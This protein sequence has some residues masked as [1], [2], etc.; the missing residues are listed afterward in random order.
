[1]FLMSSSS[2]ATAFCASLPIQTS[3][4]PQ[5]LSHHHFHHHR[6]LPTLPRSRPRIHPCHNPT[7]SSPHLITAVKAPVST[8]DAVKHALRLRFPEADIS[9]VLDSFSSAMSGVTLEKDTD[10]ARHQRA[11]SFMANISEATPFHDIST[12]DSYNW[13]RNLEANAQKIIDEFNSVTSQ[14]D[15]AEKG[16]NVWAS[17]VV[18]AATTYGPDWRTLVLQDRVWDDTN[19][20]L[21]PVTTSLLKECGVPS[22]EAFFARQKAGTG[23][24][25]HTD[26]C[27]F[28]LTMHLGLVVPEDGKSWIQVGGEKQTWQKGKAMVFD[29][30][31]FHETMNEDDN[32]D[33]V[34][35]IIRFWHPDM[36]E[37]ERDAMA[38]LFQLIEDPDEHPAVAEASELLE[39]ANMQD[40]GGSPSKRQGAVGKK[41]AKKNTTSSP[42]RGFGKK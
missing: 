32:V 30:S 5:W 42:A 23:I 13:V 6:L 8:S 27:N 24:R 28:V 10:A 2:P 38:Y 15:L 26:D 39:M 25:L 40:G 14:P 20:K 18:E 3:T 37:I 33:R 17:A 41:G 31:F 35:L 11:T 4:E 22:V 29:T 9:R 21:F 12:S 36:Q 19:T 16:T 1:M 34:V 7:T